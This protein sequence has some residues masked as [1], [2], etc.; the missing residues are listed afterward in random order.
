MPSWW[1]A[2]KT[3][4]AIEQGDLGVLAIGMSL[5]LL[6]FMHGFAFPPRVTFSFTEA[7]WL[8]MMLIPGIIGLFH[9]TPTRVLVATL[10]AVVTICLGHSVAFHRGLIHQSFEAPRIVM[11]IGLY[12]F[13]LTGMGGPLHWLRLHHVRDY[14]QNDKACPPYFSYKHSLLTEIWWNLHGEY[15]PRDPNEVAKLGELPDLPWL[16]FLERS[17]PLHNLLLGALL[18]AID[19]W[20]M[21]LVAGCLRTAV[22][23]LGHCTINYVAHTRGSMRY[24]IGD[25]PEQGRNTCLLGI[26]SFGEGFHNNHHAYPASARMGQT[27]YEIDLGWYALRGLE[28]VGVVR[29][30]RAF[31]REDSGI[32]TAVSLA[33]KSST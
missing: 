8:Y 2:R 7:G 30:M 4:E 16:R 18:Y 20:G 24:T 19:G 6:P 33:T 3:D 9:L 26:L 10:L 14:W 17:W 22:G 12:L 1:T 27:W 32:R 5:A 29:N 31:G 11:R 25:A 23:I 13:V 28:A 21:V 15:E